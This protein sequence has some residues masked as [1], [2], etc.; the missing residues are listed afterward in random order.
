M[1]EIQTKNDGPEP[2]I[3]DLGKQ[4]KGRVKDLR[5]GRGRL[6][7]DIAIAL[8]ELKD[9]DIVKDGAQPV[10]IIVREK[11]KKKRWLI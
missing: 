9:Q 10:I 2:V 5:K 8:E 4:K 7:S 6:M 11:S 1:N 3:L